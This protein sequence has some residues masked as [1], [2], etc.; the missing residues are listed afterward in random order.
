MSLAQIKT[1]QT[2]AADIH[3]WSVSPTCLNLWLILSMNVAYQ[4]CHVLACSASW[5][6]LVGLVPPRSTL[7]HTMTSNMLLF[8]TCYLLL[9]LGCVGQVAV[10]IWPITIIE[11]ISDTYICETAALLY[12]IIYFRC[13]GTIG[14]L[15][16]KSLL[17]TVIVDMYII[18]FFKWL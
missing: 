5:L 18:C 1:P 4:C 13:C 10:R 2:T 8:W 17:T 14:A 11:T 3:D 7:G 15:H 16:S 12:I 9:C 6:C